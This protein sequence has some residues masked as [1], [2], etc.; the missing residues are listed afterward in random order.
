M[1]LFTK[2]KHTYRYWKQTYVY[3]RGNVGWEDKSGASDYHK[4]TTIYK[5]DNQQYLLYSTGN[6]TQYSLITYMRKE[7]KKEWINIYIYIYTYIYIYITESL[8]STPETNTTL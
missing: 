1:I 5:I 8:C 6:S 3:Q 2:Q 4:H 7:T